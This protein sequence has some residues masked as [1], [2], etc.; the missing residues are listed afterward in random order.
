MKK[1][2]LALSLALVLCGC[3]PVGE[4]AE[5]AEVVYSSAGIDETVPFRSVGELAHFSEVII[6]AT[7]ITREEAIVLGDYTPD[8]LEPYRVQTDSANTLPNGALLYVRTPYTVKISAI[9]KQDK[10]KDGL[11]VDGVL[12]ICALGGICRGI[13]VDRGSV[14]LTPGKDYIIGLTRRNLSSGDEPAYTLSHTRTAAIAVEKIGTTLNEDDVEG[15]ILSGYAT[16]DDFAAAL[17]QQVDQMLCTTTILI[18][19]PSIASRKGLLTIPDLLVRATVERCED[20]ILIG[21]YADTDISTFN[22]AAVRAGRLSNALI[23]SVHTPYTVTLDAIYHQNGAPD[24]LAV[25]QTMQVCV[26]GGLAQGVSVWSEN[27]ILTP[28]TTYILALRRKTSGDGRVWYTLQNP[29]NGA[30]A[31]T[32]DGHFAPAGYHSLSL[33]DEYATL[34][35]FEAALAAEAAAQP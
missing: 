31:L 5:T 26:G 13:E 4:P 10:A 29:S 17:C 32:A 30:V 18:E 1:R 35:D 7:V 16:V 28:G 11:T 22:Q 24:T 12:P 8:D 20:G 3:S 9:Y 33:Y 19:T 21:D 15:D 6:R 27:P 34:A 23:E 14:E 25:G 2:L